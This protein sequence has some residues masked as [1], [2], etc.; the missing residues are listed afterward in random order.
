MLSR[1]ALTNQEEAQAVI[2]GFERQKPYFGN[3]TRNINYSE[4][5]LWEMWQHSVAAGAEL[6]FARMLGKKD[7]VPSVNKWKTELDIPG[8]GEVRYSMT[9]KGLRYT[10]RDNDQLVYV[11]LTEGLKHRIRRTAPE[12]NGPEYLAVGWKRGADCKRDEWKY[13]ETTWYV[14]IQNLE[15]METL[16]V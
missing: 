16:N 15:P 8:L 11:L 14:P 13:N 7:F 1:Y 12:W 9:N 4:G 5:D 6:A 10:V 2:I 3:P